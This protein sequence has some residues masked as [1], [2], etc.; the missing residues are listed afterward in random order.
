MSCERTETWSWLI[1]L[2]EA[3]MV[4]GVYCEV[5]VTV[6]C[7]P[8]KVS[9]TPPPS[10]LVVAFAVQIATPGDAEAIA[11]KVHVTFSPCDITAP[12]SVAVILMDVDEK[13]EF[14]NV[15]GLRIVTGEKTVNPVGIAMFAEPNVLS[16]MF[17]MITEYVTSWLAL[18]CEG[19][20]SAVNE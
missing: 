6:G 15:G 2:G 4:G 20:I 17:V 10:M 18:T 11:S 12:P 8:C 19:N 5:T 16:P 3:D 1:A 14:H 7:S 13:L 9:S